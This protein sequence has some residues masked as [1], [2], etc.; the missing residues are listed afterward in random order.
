MLRR[1][2]WRRWTALTLAAGLLLMALTYNHLPWRR[3]PG[4]NTTD[5]GAQPAAEKSPL[6]PI[7]PVKPD[8]YAESP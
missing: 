1:R 5:D 8:A 4:E 6:P 3:V 2:R 7:P